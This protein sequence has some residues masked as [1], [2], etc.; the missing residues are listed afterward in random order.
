MLFNSQFNR[1]ATNKFSK[2]L[3]KILFENIND[4]TRCRLTFPNEIHENP[5]IWK[6]NI[7]LVFNIFLFI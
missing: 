3:L 7:G 6:I 2:N 4:S 5:F 1:T